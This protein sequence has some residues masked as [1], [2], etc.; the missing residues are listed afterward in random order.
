MDVHVNL[1]R[2]SY[3]NFS[4]FFFRDYFRVFAGF[5]AKSDQRGARKIA[6]SL[7]SY[8]A[9]R[10]MLP[11]EAK[12]RYAIFTKGRQRCAKCRLK[13]HKSSLHFIA[14]IS[15]NSNSIF[16]QR[17]FLSSIDAQKYSSRSDKFVFASQSAPVQDNGFYYFDLTIKY[18]GSDPIEM[19]MCVSPFV[20]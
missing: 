16:Y 18:Q 11:L 12:F 6:Q 10:V 13:C 9:L 2:V 19:T 15:A 7:L 14:N 4:E 17:E 3:T 20:S 8:L 5:P 1:P